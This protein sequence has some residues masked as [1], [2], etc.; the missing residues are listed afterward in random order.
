MEINIELEHKILKLMLLDFNCV[1]MGAEKLQSKCFYSDYGK[2]LFTKIKDYYNKYN[3]KITKNALELMLNESF[4]I[5]E[6]H[7]EAF[8]FIKQLLNQKVET[9][10]FNYLIDQLKNVYLANTL[11]NEID[12]V[13]TNIKPETIIKQIS[14]LSRKL[15]ELEIPTHSLIIR[16]ANLNT[17]FFINF[18]KIEESKMGITTGYTELDKAIKGFQKQQL[19]VIAAPS[20][21]GKSMMLE[22]LAEN[23]N[24]AG[25]NV[26]CITKEMSLEDYALRRAGMVAKIDSNILR[27]GNLNGELLKTFYLRIFQRLFDSKH[28]KDIENKFDTIDFKEKVDMNDLFEEIKIKFELTKTKFFVVDI[29]KDCTIKRIENELRNALKTSEI[30]LLIIDYFYILDCTQFAPTLWEKYNIMIRELKELARQYNIPIVTAAQLDSGDDDVKIKQ[31]DIRYARAI[32][33]NADWVIAWKRT[34]D[35][36]LLSRIRLEVSKARYA[37]KVMIELRENYNHATIEN[38]G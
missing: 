34:E 28:S 36:K 29:P 14:D 15:T 32:W 5:Q 23:A 9:A 26:M 2:W 25:Y 16:S 20:G 4:A 7:A 24:A 12:N 19:S 37:K 22:N 18:A 30:H 3:Q 35:D 10:E 21:E 17:E 6:K 1:I 11:L 38:I 8:L 31:E 27:E 33:E 13:A